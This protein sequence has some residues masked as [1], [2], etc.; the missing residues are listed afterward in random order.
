ME[1]NKIDMRP[2]ADDKLPIQ[3]PLA[4][5]ILLVVLIPLL[6]LGWAYLRD[7]S[8]AKGFGKIS[9]GAT[10][11]D[12]VR[13][14]GRPKKVEMCGEFFGP[15]PES[16]MQHCVSEYLYAATF[17][18]YTPSYYIVRFDGAGHVISKVP[19]SSP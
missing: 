13:L 5:P 3:W 6:V 8:L 4:L 19:L 15:I 16:E 10:Q 1:S 7:G 14:M 12:V 11:Q 2:P 17:A 9:D 18:P